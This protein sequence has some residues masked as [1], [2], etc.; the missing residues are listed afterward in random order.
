MNTESSEDGW[1]SF[2]ELTAKFKK[3]NELSE[4]FDL[5]LLWKK[6]RIYRKGIV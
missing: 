5:S 3:S 6:K 4:L 2:L 1:R